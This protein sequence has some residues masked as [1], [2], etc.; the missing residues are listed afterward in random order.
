MNMKKMFLRFGTV[1]VFSCVPSMYGAVTQSLTVSD[2][3][4]DSITVNQDGTFSTAGTVTF[5]A[6][7]ITV[8][9]VGAIEIQS[10]LSGNV[11]LGAAGP[12]QFKINS[13]SAFGLADSIPPQLQDEESL[14]TTSSGTGTLT[15]QYT[16]TTYTN[17]APGLLLSGS[18]ST[19]NTPKT[20]VIFKANAS[21]EPL[22][23]V[24][25]NPATGV[26]GS[27]GPLS[28]TSDSTS[29]SFANTA[30]GPHA[31][32]TS[33]STITFSGAGTFNTTFDIASV[34]EPTSVFL[35]GTLL[36]GFSI[37][38]RTKIA[39]RRA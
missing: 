23:P 31:S 28:G 22:F 2:G 13:A 25:V 3:L 6:G 30:T 26:V 11:L 15:I 9:G 20:S 8:D 34:P 24:T 7:N 32:L 19:S 21:N 17:L 38:L 29:A 18:E 14:D 5:A 10:D 37:I 36:L 35:F 4:G 27:L 33:T 1:A 16:D 12:G 39:K